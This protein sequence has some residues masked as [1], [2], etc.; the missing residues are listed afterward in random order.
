MSSTPL[1]T[2]SLAEMPS[3]QRQRN[4][5]ASPEYAIRVKD[6]LVE[7]SLLIGVEGTGSSVR[8][9]IGFVCLDSFGRAVI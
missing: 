7:E 8:R 1:S 3:S 6:A 4:D 9:N 2:R 5:G